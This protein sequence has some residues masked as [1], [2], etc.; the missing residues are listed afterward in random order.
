MKT[1]FLAIAA[2]AA[3]TFASAQ[4]TT[5]TDHVE[6]EEIALEITAEPFDVIEVSN[7]TNGTRTIVTRQNGEYTLTAVFCLPLMSAELDKKNV[8]G[9]LN[10]AKSDLIMEEVTRGTTRHEIASTACDYNG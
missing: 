3:G 4:E 7:T 9:E 1:A 2:I 10:R 6:T 8:V 5:I